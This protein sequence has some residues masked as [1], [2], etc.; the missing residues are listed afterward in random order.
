[1]L[2]Q[3]FWL[4]FVG[5]KAIRLMVFKPN[6]LYKS[7]NVQFSFALARKKR[8]LVN[9]THV[10]FCFVICITNHL[11]LACPKLVRFT[12]KTYLHELVASALCFPKHAE[13]NSKFQMKTLPIKTI[14]PVPTQNKPSYHPIY[15]SSHGCRRVFEPISHKSDYL[16]IQEPLW[17]FC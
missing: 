7:P 3:R 14:E 16:L 6:T 4:T 10:I 12:I 11:H 9:K 13:N 2:K 15:I 17:N 1:M 8:L 5:F